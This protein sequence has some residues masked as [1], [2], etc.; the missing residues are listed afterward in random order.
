M[1][2][3][4]REHDLLRDSRH[5]SCA[6][7]REMADWLA[8]LE[9]GGAAAST[10][11]GYEWVVARL[12]RFNESKTL[13]EFTDA[14]I[15]HVLGTFPPASRR[16]RAQ[17]IKSFVK[18]GLRTRRIERNPFDLLPEIKRRPQKVIDV[19]SDAEIAV[20]TSLPDNDGDLMLILFDA[21]LRRSEARNLQVRN[22]IF[23]REELVVLRGKGGKDRAIPM[24]SRL[25]AALSKWCL[26]DAFEDDDYLWATRPG[27]YYLRRTK[28]MGDTSFRSWWE[29][30]I[31]TSGVRYRN[32][33]TTRHTFA[34]RWLRRGGRLET[35][36]RAMGHS[37][38]K[39]TAD[40]YAHLNTTDL[41]VDL[42]LIE[43]GV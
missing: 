26:L 2:V 14:D 29:R 21:G 34:T 7:A 43:G 32:P 35:L 37:S 8:W 9:L 18:W 27:G 11:Y 41:A 19:F 42:R 6:A 22:I 20:L 30:S 40:L 16:E 12:L 24:T 10:L 31:E 4:L 33:H 17:A 15:A 23:D 13:A 25:T 39:V 38:I 1:R 3:P 5:E 36:S 28:P